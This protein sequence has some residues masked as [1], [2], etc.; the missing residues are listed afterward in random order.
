M[1]LNE[2]IKVVNGTSNINSEEIITKIKTDSRDIKKGDIFIALKGKKYDGHDYI[3]EAINN[4]ATTCI[5]EEDINDRCIKVKS[6]KDSLFYIGNYIRKQNNIPVICITGSNG[7][8]TTKEL[9][10][11]IL[12]SKYNVL[13]NKDNENNIYGVS[14]ML[15]NLNKDYDIVVIE[16]GSNHI[17]EISL[18]SKTCNP[19]TSIITNIGSSHLEYFKNRKNIF[20]E[21]LSIIDGMKNNE[22]I[23]NGDDKYLKKLNYYKCG[24]NKNNNLKLYLII[25]V[26]IL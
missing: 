13:Y 2:L 4:G 25:Q 17:G 8:T 16:L 14:N 3:D 5:V 12:K 15:F 23:I 11:H 10:V 9:I 1:T 18:L 21:K 6:T 26:N 19:T 22:L 24:L 20:K 7:K